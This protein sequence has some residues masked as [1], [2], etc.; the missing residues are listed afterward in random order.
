MVGKMEINISQ[1]DRKNLVI[2]ARREAEAL[3]QLYDT[4]YDKVLR[5]C[6]YRLFNREVA[7]DVTSVVFL[8]E[9]LAPCATHD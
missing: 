6:V 2:R 5:F 1:V 8:P 4:Y 3:G 7:E 9:S